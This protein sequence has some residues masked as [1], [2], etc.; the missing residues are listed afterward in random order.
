METLMKCTGAF[1]VILI[2]GLSVLVG[3]VD[4]SSDVRVEE[5]SVSVTTK[6]KVGV[7]ITENMCINPTSGAIEFC[8]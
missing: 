1:L 6:G 8:L 3:F 2:L 5:N 4:D 7:N